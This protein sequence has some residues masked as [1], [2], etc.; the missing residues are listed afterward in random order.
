MAVNNQTN[1][2]FRKTVAGVDTIVTLGL[3][4]EEYNIVKTLTQINPPKTKQKQSDGSGP[5]D[6]KILDLLRIKETFEITG[7]LFEGSFTDSDVGVA[8]TSS[9]AKD[10]KTN[11][12]SIVLAG[13]SFTIYYDG[14]TYNVNCEKVNFKRIFKESALVDGDAGYDVKLSLVIGVDL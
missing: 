6:T 4:A 10:R 2:T 1:I 11:L 8:D 5:K 13:Q 14:D 12:K 3:T 9:T 7:F